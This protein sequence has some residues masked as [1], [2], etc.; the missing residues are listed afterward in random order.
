MSPKRRITDLPLEIRQQIFGDY[1]KVQGGYVYDGQADK[2]RNADNTPVNLSLV[3]TCR[4]IANDCKNL[5]LAVNTIHFSTLYREDWRSLAGCFNLAATYYYVLQQDLVLHLGHLMTPDMHAQME[6]KMPNFQSKLEAEREFH[7]HAW[8][9]AY[10]RN[11]P[12]F[13]CQ[14]V[15]DFYG[16]EVRRYERPDLW[17]YTGYASVHDDIHSCPSQYLEH[18]NEIRWDTYSGEVRQCLDHCLRLI[19]DEYPG[20]F[21]NRVYAY[22]PHWVDK[23]PAQDFFDLRFDYWAIP[24]HSQLASVMDR[25]GIPDFVW[26]LPNTWSYQWKSE[27]D[28]R[29]DP[30]P[31]HFLDDN[32]SPPLEFKAR[33][34]E[35]IMFSAAAAAIRFLGLLSNTQRTGIRT[36]ILREDCPSV[37]KP[38]LHGNGLLPFLKENPCLRIQRRVNI[39][40]TMEFYGS[41]HRAARYLVTSYDADRPHNGLYDTLYTP[42]LSQWLLDAIAVS[43]EDI[44]AGS[45]TLL[46]E[47]GPYN[48]FCTELFQQ[49]VHRLIALSRAFYEC[50]EGGLLKDL[51][52]KQVKNLMHEFSLGDGFQEAMMQLVNQTSIVL[53]SDFNPGVPQSHQ[54]IIDGTRAA[55]DTSDYWDSL[56][57]D[58]TIDLPPKVWDREALARRFD[59]QTGDEYIQSRACDHQ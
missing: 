13:V 1:F 36:I 40:N 55:L 29:R 45:L 31:N 15:R 46:L 12:P 25:L 57:E 38:S 44:S 32:E 28:D 8:G 47:S 30:P 34:R 11:M 22:L 19:A 6:K 54:A 20:E 51:T 2:L 21:G 10:Y 50:L 41:P 3:Y 59:L 49:R 23:Y 7:L 27:H 17:Y 48:D 43:K 58:D 4:S 39:V 42:E 52:G 37:N 35:K 5:P 16:S 53:H 18:M 33:A 14:F 24:S 26:K 56:Y 9:P